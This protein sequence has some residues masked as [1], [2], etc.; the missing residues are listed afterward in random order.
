[1]SAL[2]TVAAKSRADL[3]REI[4]QHEVTEAVRDEVSKTVGAVTQEAMTEE[5]LKHIRSFVFLVPKALQAIEKNL[6]AE[7]ADVRQKAAQTLLR[8]TL[9]NTSVAPP[10]IEQEKQPMQVVFSI[11]RSDTVGPAKGGG[12]RPLTVMPPVSDAMLQMP[13]FVDVE[14]TDLDDIDTCTKK[15]CMECGNEKCEDEFVGQSYRC[16]DCDRRLQA[17]VADQFGKV[18]LG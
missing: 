10:S 4:A 16:K 12:V 6:D 11:P 7:D 14:S 5:V 8:Y 9:G 2:R 18:D 3:E 13:A 17:R 1:M 15:V